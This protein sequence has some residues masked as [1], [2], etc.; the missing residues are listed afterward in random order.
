MRTSTMAAATL[1]LALA[2]AAS[3]HLTLA[4]FAASSGDDRAAIRAWKHHLD[5]GSRRSIAERA[6]IRDRTPEGTRRITLKSDAKREPPRKATITDAGVLA[7]PMLERNPM[8]GGPA[9]RGTSKA[10]K[11]PR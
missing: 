1:V 7:A 10:K 5:A 4:R 6:A 11:K 9:G 3:A 2:G 8:A